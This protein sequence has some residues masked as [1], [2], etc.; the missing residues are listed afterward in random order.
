MIILL[1]I[2]L[3]LIIL[4]MNKQI[5]VSFKLYVLKKTLIWKPLNV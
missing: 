4:E 5:K 1:K 2:F 3:H